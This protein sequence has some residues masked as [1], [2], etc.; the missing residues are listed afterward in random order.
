MSYTVTAGVQEGLGHIAKEFV[1]AHSRYSHSRLATI[2]DGRSQAAM[3]RHAQ[4]AL[5]AA[6]RRSTARF[7][8]RPDVYRRACVT[9]CGKYY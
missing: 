4:V 7:R 5:S 6:S 8:A 9:F 2:N 3:A 1:T